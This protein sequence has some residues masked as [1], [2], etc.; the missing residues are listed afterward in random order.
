MPRDI[1]IDLFSDTLTKPTLGMRQFMCNAE[2]GDEQKGED[3][4]VNDLQEM[5]ADLLGKEAA[6][7]LPSGTMCNLISIRLHCRPGDEILL[8]R[9]AHPLNSEGAGAAVLSGSLIQ[10]LSGERGVFFASAAESGNPSI[11][12]LS[13]E[14]SPGL[15]GADVQHGGRDHL[16]A[17]DNSG[18]LRGG[19][20]AS[21]THPHGWSAI[22]ECR[23]RD[24]DS[25]ERICQHF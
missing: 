4:T 11:Q 1:K 3:P 23:C 14:D 20:R 8:D 15:G 19:A 21:L 5:V 7:F 13:T 17:G 24:K 10:G 9:T 16:A 12:P 25:G 18:G 22:D 6:L 2:V